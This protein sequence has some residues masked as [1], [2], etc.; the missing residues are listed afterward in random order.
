M[1]RALVRDILAAEGLAQ[2]DRRALE[3]LHSLST[4]LQH[5]ALTPAALQL[6]QQWLYEAQEAL[7]L[8]L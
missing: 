1:H 8:H 2:L 7:R 6:A 3:S 5:A 4:L